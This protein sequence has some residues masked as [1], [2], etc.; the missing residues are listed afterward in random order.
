MVRLG[1]GIVE[2]DESYDMGEM[3]NG[4]E[5]L[6]AAIEVLEKVMDLMLRWEGVGWRAALPEWLDMGEE[7]SDGGG[8]NKEEEEE[9][10]DDEEEERAVLW[11]LKKER[12]REKKRESRRRR[13]E[14]RALERKQLVLVE[15]KPA[16]EGGKET[17]TFRLQ[18]AKMSCEAVW[19]AE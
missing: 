11:G 19:T 5:V 9:K 10:S 15:E 12:I 14:R 18:S 3:M 4:S 16:Q 2:L 1:S 13:R 6:K 7:N 8:T 17:V